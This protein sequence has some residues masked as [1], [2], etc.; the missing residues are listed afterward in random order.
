MARRQYHGA[1]ARR[2]DRR[3]ATF[4]TRM[5]A[6]IIDLLAPDLRPG[7]RVL[8][9]G[10]GT[11]TL[12]TALATRQPDLVLTG[13][14]ASPDMLAQAQAKLGD[15]A[16]ML[17]LD[18]NNPLPDAVRQ[19][20]HVDLVLCVSVLHYLRDPLAA[21]QALAG[22]LAPD[23]SMLLADFTRHGWWWPG[24]EAVLHL[25]D[26]QHQRT[27]TADALPALLRAAGLRPTAPHTV[28]AGGPWRG[29]IAKGI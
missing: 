19:D 9:V 13:T 22:L 27:L 29:T 18:L 12:L 25:A 2:Y 3:W 6:P 17:I 7:L 16:N 4:T 5:Q 14:D 10:C 8:D 20:L 21:V 15:R 1:A 26:A 28:G 23:G 24:F 11:G